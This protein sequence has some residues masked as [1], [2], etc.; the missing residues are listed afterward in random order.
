MT[1]IA[2]TI[3][4]RGSDPPPYSGP[5]P[6]IPSLVCIDKHPTSPAGWDARKNRC[7]PARRPAH[8]NIEHVLAVHGLRRGDGIGLRSFPK[9]MLRTATPQTLLKLVAA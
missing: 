1:W 8:H 4:R 9:T 5:R 2:R 6:Q 3:R 7:L